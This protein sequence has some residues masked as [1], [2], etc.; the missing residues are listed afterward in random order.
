MQDVKPAERADPCATLIGDIVDSRGAPDRHALHT[1]LVSTLRRTDH[2]VAATTALRITVGDEF[3]ASYETLGNALE[4]AFRIRLGLMPETLVRFG[5]SWGGATVLDARAGTQDGPAWWAARK[6]IEAAQAAERRPATHAVR[7]VYTPAQDDGPSA[8]AVN[9]ALVCQ[10]QLL[11][12]LDERAMRILQRLVAGESRTE[13]ARAEDV[14][15]S[16]ISQRIRAAGL[17]V[18]VNAARDLASV[19]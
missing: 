2:L 11:S 16:A 1:R 12:S 4:A 3:Q 7:T 6:A 9:A 19:R 18:I 5:L 17:E 13:I 14:S 10:D 15:P 8:G